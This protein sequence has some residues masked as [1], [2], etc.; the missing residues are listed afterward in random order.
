MLAAQPDMTVYPVPANNNMFVEF[1]MEGRE[2]VNLYLTNM[3]GKVVYMAKDNASGN[4]KQQIA[5]NNLPAGN[6]VLCV[7]SASGLNMTKRINVI[8]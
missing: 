4:Y 1:D 7:K 6:Y 2:E 5:V 8:H 3:A